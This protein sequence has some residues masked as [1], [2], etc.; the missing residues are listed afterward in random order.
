MRAKGKPEWPFNTGRTDIHEAC[1]DN[2]G[3]LDRS[4]A[5]HVLTDYMKPLFQISAHPSVHLDTGRIKHNPLGVQNMYDEQPW[6]TQGTGCWNV[7]FWVLSNLEVSTGE[8]VVN[9]C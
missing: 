9:A 1:L 7:L 6:K 5:S 2:I 4:T 8:R 3:V